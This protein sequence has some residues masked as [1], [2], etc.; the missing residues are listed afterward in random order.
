[1]STRVTAAAAPLLSYLEGE[2]GTWRP[3]MGC[4]LL[5]KATCDRH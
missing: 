5:G 2:L 4:A 3:P 1:M